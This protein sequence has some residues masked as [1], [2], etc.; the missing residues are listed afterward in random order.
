MPI[1]AMSSSVRCE[2]GREQ[3]LKFDE[4]EAVPS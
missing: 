2:N 3:R 1:K 4:G